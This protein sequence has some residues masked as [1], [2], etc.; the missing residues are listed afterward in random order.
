MPLPPAFKTDDSFLQKIAMGATAT[1]R[2][3][4]DLIVHGHD[5][6]EL[7]RGTTSVKL[8]KRKMKRLRVPDILCLRCG[9]RVESRGKS[10]LEITMSHSARNPERGWDA[11]L[12]DLDV[13]ALV[14]CTKT[15][16]G[17]LD[18]RAH[19][20]VQYVGVDALRRAARAN[21]IKTQG[22]KGAQEGFE[23][24]VTWP[25]RVSGVIG[26]VE[27]VDKGTVVVRADNGRRRT[28][29]LIAGRTRLA[30]AVK[31]GEKVDEYR[32]LAAVVP[33]RPSFPCP[34][35]A[36]LQTYLKLARSTSVPDR[37]TAIK[38][39]G[40]FGEG[41]AQAVL[42]ERLNDE[43]EHLYVRLE[44]AAG[45]LRKGEVEAARFF[46]TTLK[47]DYLEPRLEAVIV[48]TEVAR[49]EAAAIL[50]T[51]LADAG[52]SA[53]VRAGAAWALGVV[54]GR[55]A[56]P[57]LIA[58]FRE[59]DIAVRIEAARA[60]GQL[61]R[62]HLPDLLAALPKST[63]EERPGIAWALASAGGFTIA[64]VLPALV[65]EDARHWVAYVVGT[66]DP[67]RFLA[68][69]GDLAR[70]DPEVYFAAT[71]L[72]KILSSWIDGLEAY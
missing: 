26:V 31:P 28:V 14:A 16:P 65:D 9:R 49:P 32:I 53:D 59:L 48:L 50:L 70:R 58:A 51:A 3:I 68:G 23:V 13:V 33:V 10:K 57:A 17:P 24:R 6:L 62:H 11:G 43:R 35:G 37:Y 54:G 27:V 29:R 69:I 44:A 20:V 67:A 12:D 52:Q 21:K 8:W 63:V 61:A 15:G 56:L 64:D 2:T 7:E 30:A 66:Q 46:E 42:R 45:L 19:D 1:R 22:A 72:W 41:D 47:D 38:A 40:R 55:N 39:L 71:V 18:W 4:Q 5:P 60:L 25:A 34:G 36:T